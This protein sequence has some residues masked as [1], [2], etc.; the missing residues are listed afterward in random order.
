LPLEE[1]A[2]FVP[3]SGNILD[4]GCGYGLLDIYLARTAPN[5]NVIGSEL[6]SKRV[7]IAQIISQ[8]IPNVKFFEKNLLAESDVVNI[9][10]VDC[11]ILMD[12]LHH[13]TYQQQDELI[14]T[15]HNILPQGGK[16]LIKDM[17]DRP[18]FKYYWNLV[19]D[20]LMTKFD[21]LHFVGSN[22]L[23]KRIEKMGFAVQSSSKFKHPLYAH[24]LLVCE[25][26]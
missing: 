20:K 16:L 8:D 5:R 2:K 24:Y 23:I 1:I 13:V 11:I 19:H 12:L 7:R 6:N 21:K 3:T 26:E 22:N 15:I 4:V 14:K 9:D 10:Q 25:K 18:V 17:D